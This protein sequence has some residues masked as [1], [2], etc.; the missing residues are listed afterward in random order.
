MRKLIAIALL[1]GICGSNVGDAMAAVHPVPKNRGQLHGGDWFPYVLSKLAPLEWWN[2][3]ES[4][5]DIK[6]DE[7]S[8]KGGF[9]LARGNTWEFP[10]F[11]FSLF[12]PTLESYSA[13][14]R[15]SNN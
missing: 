9:L 13:L 15:A 4:V 10:R 5:S 7:F 6:A 8:G 3:S 11:C 2:F 1:L 14:I 12:R